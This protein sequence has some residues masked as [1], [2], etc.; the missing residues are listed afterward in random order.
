M[1]IP[2]K[3]SKSDYA[4]RMPYLH[5]SQLRVFLF[6]L[7]ACCLSAATG[8]SPKISDGSIA[9]IAVSDSASRHASDRSRTV[10]V[11][12]RS[13]AEYTERRIPGAIRIDL[14]TFDA[15]SPPAA[16]RS[17]REI[18]V[19]GQDPGSAT[20]IAL[21]KRLMQAGYSR[22]YL[23]RDGMNGWVARSLPTQSG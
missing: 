14:R 7:C 22:V 1:K 19:Y 17:A 12:A 11:D 21:T 3:K 13:A 4:K 8:C 15:Q 16:L 5:T 10:F 18:I 23:M 2:M 6:V 9:N 20:A